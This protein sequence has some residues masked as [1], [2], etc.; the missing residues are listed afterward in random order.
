MSVLQFLINNPKKRDKICEILANI[1]KKLGWTEWNNKD[2]KKI[3]NDIVDKIKDLQV[4]VN[5]PSKF[6]GII[7][8]E[9]FESNLD[10]LIKISQET[11]NYVL[12]PRKVSPENFKNFFLYAF[13]GKDIDF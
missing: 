7:S 12:S 8:K 4:K 5:F 11:P 2:D 6:E 1:A 3:A 13:Q 10:L 9:D